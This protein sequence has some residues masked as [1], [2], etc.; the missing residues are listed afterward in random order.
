MNLVTAVGFYSI[1]GSLE[2]SLK[3]EQKH[4]M[5][6]ALSVQVFPGVLQTGQKIIE[7]MGEWKIKSG[8][9]KRITDHLELG[10]Q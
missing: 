10:T 4:E 6:T 7:K 2:S 8:R 9:S 5:V 3:L 1:C